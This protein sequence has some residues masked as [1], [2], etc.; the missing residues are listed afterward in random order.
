VL[1]D[2]KLDGVTI[3]SSIFSKNPAKRVFRFLNNSTSLL[4]DLQIMASV[5]TKIFLPAALLTILGVKRTLRP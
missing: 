3:F 5:P 2:K 1:Q 4:E